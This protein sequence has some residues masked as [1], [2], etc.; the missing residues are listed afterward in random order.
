MGAALQY[1]SS[2][3][4]GN[5]AFSSESYVVAGAA[6]TLLVSIGWAG[7]YAYFVQTQP[8]T[9]RRWL[10]AGAAYGLIVYVLMQLLLLGSGRL[11]PPANPTALV[12]VV[13]AYVVFFGIPVAYVVRALTPSVP[14]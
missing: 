5:V 7:G 3:V 4:F 1:V 9:N 12:N 10:L 14:A 8:A 11:I 6:I 13:A 2:T